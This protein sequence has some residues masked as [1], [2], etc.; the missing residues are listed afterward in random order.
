MKRIKKFKEWLDHFRDQT[1]MECD[2]DIVD[3]NMFLK[4]IWTSIV[5]CLM[6]VACMIG[7]PLSLVISIILS[8]TSIIVTKI[9]DKKE[10]AE[11]DKNL[12]KIKDLLNKHA[13]DVFKDTGLLYVDFKGDQKRYD[14]NSR[15]F[16][17]N[18][19][20][21]Y[22]LKF[23]T[24]YVDN[25]EAFQCSYGR[26]RSL[27]DI[28]LI[29]KNYYPEITIEEVLT[30]LIDFAEKGWIAGMHCGQ[31]HKY[32]FFNNGL[33]KREDRLEYLPDSLKFRD[34]INIYKP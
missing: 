27:G 22:N 11:H 13:N 29:T 28:Y 31:I 5:L 26:R 7:A 19:I 17:Y 10:K 34:L 2:L 9:I 1:L 24:K 20:H 14:T 15:E 18:F 33:Y 21:T 32:V 6:S 16:I 4:G 23:D 3:D 12:A 25:K 30:H 8:P